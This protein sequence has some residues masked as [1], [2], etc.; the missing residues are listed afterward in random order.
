MMII[1]FCS[2]ISWYYVVMIRI[3]VEENE[4]D[5]AAALDSLTTQTDRHIG[6]S[7]RNTSCITSV[8]GFS[9][10]VAQTERC[11]WT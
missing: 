3:I 9:T 10:P 1:L 4:C 11:G 5:Q 2:M 6:A 8:L 7:R